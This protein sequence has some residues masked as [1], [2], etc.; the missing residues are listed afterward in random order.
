MKGSKKENS[1]KMYE[2]SCQEARFTFKH[3][4]FETDRNAVFYFP[5]VLIPSK[6]NERINS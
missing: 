3:S 5:V 2:R 6:Y 1:W 4:I